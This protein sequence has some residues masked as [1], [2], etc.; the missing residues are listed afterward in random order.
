M[1]IN[2]VS[3]DR[4]Y[5]RYSAL[6]CEKVD[7]LLPPEEWPLLPSKQHRPKVETVHCGRCS[8][9]WHDALCTTAIGKLFAEGA[10]CAD[11][12]LRVR[13]SRVG[14]KRAAPAIHGIEW[15]APHTSSHSCQKWSPL[16]HVLR[17]HVQACS[18]AGSH[19]PKPM[20]C[21]F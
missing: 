6:L 4:L 11:C 3:H 2:C 10:C 8:S 21:A 12:V 16:A 14:M 15:A 19:A 1:L 17:I 18:G 7:I 13:M 20:V 5:A 9:T